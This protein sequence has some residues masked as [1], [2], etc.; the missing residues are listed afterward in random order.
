MVKIGLMLDMPEGKLPG[1]YAQIVKG[2]AQRVSLFDRDKE[3]LVLN[4]IEERDAVLELLEHYHIPSEE[5][6]LLLIPSDSY[7]FPAF[8]DYGFT[9]RAERHYLYAHLVSTFRFSVIQNAQSNPENALLQMEEHL[10][11]RFLDDNILNFV[12]DLQFIE[13]IERI[14]IAYGCSVEFDLPR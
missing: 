5:M 9:S 8:S 12:V 6:Q 13:L 7:L 14:A 11:A 1:F 10:L 3:L 2:L 4:T